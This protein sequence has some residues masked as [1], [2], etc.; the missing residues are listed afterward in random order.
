MAALSI[1]S[2]DWKEGGVTAYLSPG[3]AGNNRCEAP[4]TG[5]THK[6]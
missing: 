3:N 5:R 2:Q 6:L 4:T 1:D